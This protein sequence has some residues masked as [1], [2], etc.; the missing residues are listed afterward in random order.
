M[1]IVVIPESDVIIHAENKKIIKH[2]NGQTIL[3]ENSWAS[4]KFSRKRAIF[5]IIEEK[6]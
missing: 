3:E 4:S 5:N 2:K 6:N 1:Q